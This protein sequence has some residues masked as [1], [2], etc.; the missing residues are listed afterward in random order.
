M[1]HR[2]IGYKFNVYAK[3]SLK[4][5]KVY[6]P[7]WSVS[8]DINN[9]I[10]MKLENKKPYNRDLQVLITYIWYCYCKQYPWMP[11]WSLEM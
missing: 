4:H 9:K 11:S 10:F 7:K 8:L 3:K 5:L 1:Y 6:V 2:F